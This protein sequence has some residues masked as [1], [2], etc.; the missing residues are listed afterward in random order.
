[1]VRMLTN[2]R[3]LNQGIIL[4]TIETARE[5]ANRFRKILETCDPSTTYLVPHGFPVMSCK[6]CSMLL[7]FHFL[8]L[9]PELELKGVT[10]VTGKNGAITHFW[11]EVENYVIDITG[12]Q[13]NIINASKLNE[14]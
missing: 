14:N 7:S 9:W 11:L 13:Y 6:L 4:F 12:D 10:G 2:T 3:M 5:E 8:Q 1:M